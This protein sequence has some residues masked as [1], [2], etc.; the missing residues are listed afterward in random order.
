M[1]EVKQAVGLHCKLL[2]GNLEVNAE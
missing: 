1:T 2:P